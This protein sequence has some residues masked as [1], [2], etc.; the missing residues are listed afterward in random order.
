MAGQTCLLCNRSLF[1]VNRDNAIRKLV[2]QLTP[3]RYY[4]TLFRL[5]RA[6]AVCE[7]CMK[8]I[9]VIHEE[10]C[11]HCGRKK[12]GAGAGM[13]FTNSLCWDCQ[14]LRGSALNSNR[15]ALTYN[16]WAKS[17]MAVYKYRGEMR[18]ASLFAKLLLGSY[19]QHYSQLNI[20]LITWVPLHPTRLDERG[21][22]QV[23]LFAKQLG[24]QLR[25]PAVPLLIR[26]KETAKQSKQVGKQARLKSMQN[27]FALSV[28]TASTYAHRI[29]LKSILI[30]DDIYTTGST[31]ESCARQIRLHPQLANHEIFSL[32]VCR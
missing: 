28:P 4:P 21:F 27:A 8:E 12:K 22:N 30:I 13:L 24:K 17:V 3:P 11:L 1:T 7:A 31:L 19:Y 26:E 9:D 18:V 6:E 25:I 29:T 14:S 5:I 16:E 23:E 2:S 32:T 15:S 20:G 10:I